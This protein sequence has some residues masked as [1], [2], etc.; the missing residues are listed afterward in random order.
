VTGRNEAGAKIRWQQL[1]KWKPQTVCWFDGLVLAVEAR[2]RSSCFLEI[3][4]H[5]SCA[6]R[7][8]D[9]ASGT[10]SS[11]SDSIDNGFRSI[12]IETLGHDANGGGIVNY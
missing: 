1:L 8:G 9:Q 3:R 6:V 4:P 7:S 5:A 2:Q 12:E 10:L 11:C